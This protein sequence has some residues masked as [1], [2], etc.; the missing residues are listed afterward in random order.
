MV[1]EKAQN[2]DPAAADDVDVKTSNIVALN[3]YIHI[4]KYRF[5]GRQPSKH[6]IE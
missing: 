2:A 4:N 1:I 6:K 3:L 5:C